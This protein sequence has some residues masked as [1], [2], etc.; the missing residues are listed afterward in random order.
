[1]AAG[2]IL[3][4]EVLA[5]G[6]QAKVIIEAFKDGGTYDFGDIDASVANAKLTMTVVSEGYNT[7][8]TLGTKTR[9]VYGTRVCQKAYPNQATAEETE[10]GGNVELTI[11]LSDYVY[12]DDNTGAGKSGT[13]PTVTIASGWYTDNGTGGSSAANNATTAL[14][15]TNSSTQ[16]YPK[17]IARWAVVPYQRFTSSFSLEAVAFHRFAESGK[18]VACVKFTATDGT[19]TENI[20]ATEMSKSAA[21]DSLPCYTASLTASAYTDNAVVTANFTAYPWVGDAD[22][23]LTSIGGTA[24]ALTLG[25]LPLVAD[26]DND[27]PIYFAVVDT[28]GNDTTGVASTTY[29]TAAASPFA[30]V[31]KAVDAISTANGGSADFGRVLLNAG[32]HSSLGSTGNGACTNGWVTVEPNTNTGATKATAKITGAPGAYVRGFVQLKS[33]TI[34]PTGYVM[35]G[36]AGRYLWIDDCAVNR[37]T[38]S[39]TK[40]FGEYPHIYV[41]HSTS[42]KCDAFGANGTGNVPALIRGVSATD[43]IGFGGAGYGARTVL[44]TTVNGNDARAVVLCPISASNTV[45]A[46]SRVIADANT[47]N[48]SIGGDGA[49]DH[50]AVVCNILERSAGSQTVLSLWSNTTPNTNVLV[51]HTTIAGERLNIGYN[52]TGTSAVARSNYSAKF[53]AAYRICTKHDVFTTGNAARV[54]AW[55][56]LYGVGWVGNHSESADASFPHEDGTGYRG[57]RGTHATAA[58]YVDDN[59]GASGTGNGDYTP[60]T[61][62]VLIGKIA[63]AADVV[64]P[65]DINGVAFAAGGCAGA[66]TLASSGQPLARRLCGVLHSAGASPLGIRRW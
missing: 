54:G 25:P 53:N 34:E 57:M 7:S 4:C 44:T 56:V 21:A 15:V 9:Y 16:D 5:T 24:N 50:C 36:A 32:S 10:S 12:D 26:P 1:M 48:A 51:W 58:G 42:D 40:P 65:W 33:L 47:S 18:P 60:D 37:A 22:S 61:G 45:I 66:I 64:I 6:W 62:S 8:G 14:A 27:V 55:S 20:T 59:S 30:T 17:V 29:A 43:T 46:Y 28:A 35:G 38:Y 19:N 23:T 13:A 2:D 49:Y 39:T 63:T 11:A 3:S 52:D 31:R 41:T